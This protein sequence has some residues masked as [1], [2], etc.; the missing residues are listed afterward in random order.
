MEIQGI[1]KTKWKDFVLEVGKM[2]KS[3]F[4]IE[5]TTLLLLCNKMITR[6]VFSELML[7]GFDSFREENN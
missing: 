3:E 4:R 5:I 2:D 1:P 6:D 7:Q